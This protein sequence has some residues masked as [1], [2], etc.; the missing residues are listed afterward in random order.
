MR[1]LLCLF[2]VALLAARLRADAPAPTEQQKRA[3]AL[4]KQLGARSFKVRE[5]AARELR[6]M[7]LACRDALAA[8]TRSTDAEVRRRCAELLG[9]LFR[10]QVK[11]LLA[12]K[13]G[14]PDYPLPGWK[15]FRE[16]AGHDEVARKAFVRM[17]LTDALLLETLERDPKAAIAICTE[18]HNR[19]ERRLLDS[20]WNVKMQPDEMLPII[21]V[22]CHPRE[23]VP[24]G[25]K[26]ALSASLQQPTGLREALIGETPDPLL[27]RMVLAWLD[28]QTDE[29][30]LQNA[31]QLVGGL[32]SKE[33]TGLPLK[34]I[35]QK[36]GGPYGQ[37]SALVALGLIDA[38]KH[39]TLFE[40]YLSDRGKVT[41]FII[42][43]RT[44][45]FKGETEVRD[46]ALAFLVQATG[47]KHTDY[48]FSFSRAG[49]SIVALEAGFLGFS[50]VK[51]REAAFKK[52]AA[53][54]AAR[55]PKP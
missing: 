12:D 5:K 45:R 53:W 42:N 50:S 48:G 22:M 23:K 33:M 30:S 8:G 2:S 25:L 17:S 47:Q 49:Y 18:R 10:A 9:G 13:D 51:D 36:L 24:I 21:L 7:G 52:W 27:R 26:G 34:V 20:H 38:K 15:L 35:R 32:R 31:L 4:V 43:T 16:V 39:R 40:S 41:G 37:A 54:K 14:K 3:E 1:F 6:K 55:K 44:E 11:A 19:L 28:R 46:V 29:D